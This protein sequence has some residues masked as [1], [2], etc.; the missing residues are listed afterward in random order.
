MRSPVRLALDTD[1]TSRPSRRELLR[2]GVAGLGASLVWGWASGPFSSAR[3]ED[4]SGRTIVAGA[5]RSVRPAR[6]RSCI[7]VWLGGGP[8]QLETW[9]PKPGHAN[10]GP[11]KAIDTAGGFQIA[12][13][14]PR[15]AK[16]L[17]D[18]AVIRS[19]TSP[20]GDH[21]R[22]SY[23]LHTG[24]RQVGVLT[25]PSLGAI[26][27]SELGR[28]DAELPHFVSI[29][30]SSYGAGHLGVRHSA[31][32]ISDPTKPV[33]YMQFPDGVDRERFRDRMRL[34]NVL[35]SSYLADKRGEFLAGHRTVRQKAIHLLDSPS[36]NVFDVRNEPEETR[37]A[38]GGTSFGLQAL[39]AARLV[40]KGVPFVE[41][42]HGGW[43][44]HTNNFTAVANRAQSLDPA[45][46]TLLSELRAKR[47][48]ET[49][50]VVVTGEFGRTPRIN[51]NVGRDHFPRCFSVLVAG[52]GIAEGAVIGSSS[53]DGME[54]A[55]RPVTVPD[56]YATVLTLLG[57]DPEKE[58]RTN[59]GR[60]VKLTDAGT[61]IADLI[62]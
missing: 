36:A 14:F 32:T 3:A 41:V 47:L 59:V 8:S 12:E 50:L 45:V 39:M 20:E 23:L 13:H 31:F 44:T 17:G 51:R 48:L 2:V 34:L 55:D 1:R 35:D 9:D 42:H 61:P 60:S 24:Y 52:G 33:P 53:D 58:V 6:A 26:A 56:L 25:Y 4:G 16:E 15:I 28:D 11:T 18:G 10:G 43:D 57:I 37:E 62:A 21:S 22:A 54:V 27:S 30:G 19:V 5:A 29:G 46:A 7:L 38:F 49:T 40:E